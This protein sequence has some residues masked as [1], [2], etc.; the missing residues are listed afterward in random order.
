MQALLELLW[1]GRVALFWVALQ[2]LS[3]SLYI[4][5]VDSLR[6]QWLSFLEA[7]TVAL[8]R[9]L[10][11]VSQPLL[12]MRLYCE[13]EAQNAHLLE[14]LSTQMEAAGPVVVPLHV[15]GTIHP[16]KPYQFIPVHAVYQTLHAQKNY[17]LIDAGSE[18]GVY[19]GLVVVSDR[20]LV[21][22]IAET[23]ATYSK[24]LPLFH[25]NV[26]MT[27][28][29]ARSGYLGL[30]TW[31][32]H[33]TFN[34]VVVLY[35]PLYAPIEVGEEVWTAPQSTLA[36]AGLRIGR[37]VQTLPEPAQGFQRLILRTYLDWFQLGSLFVMKPASP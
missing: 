13:L 36:P 26:Q 31:K 18:A 23:T 4:R 22:F 12:A 10:D 29:T 20:G 11:W 19:P 15:W 34:E 21:G 24:V 8:H 3:L 14:A 7:G 28:Q 2:V 33:S 37:I 1:R 30:T 9:A 5:S 27:V 25:E 35:V 6:Q 32:G 17:L 16:Q